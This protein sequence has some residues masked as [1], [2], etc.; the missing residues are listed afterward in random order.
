MQLRL[1]RVAPASYLRDRIAYRDTQA[2]VGFYTRFRWAEPPEAYV[3]RGLARELFEQRHLREI[4]SGTGPSL[5]LDLLAFEEIRAPRHVA[6][7]TVSWRL[8]D[9]RT[10]LVQRSAT[11]ERPIARAAPDDQPAAIVDAM[12]DALAAIIGAVT[13]D[14]VA[15]LS[16]ARDEVPPAVAAPTP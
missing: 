9:G 5:D 6:R 4:V 12:A 3:R 7:I 14:V 15:E 13:D 16:R 2:E 11:I 1:G 10:V 8:R